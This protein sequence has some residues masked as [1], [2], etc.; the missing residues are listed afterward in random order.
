MSSDRGVTCS[1]CGAATPLPDD[2]LVPTFACAFC[3][4]TLTTADYAGE[5]AVSADALVGHIERLA[6]DP[7]AAMA[8]LDESVRSA[9]RFA[10]GS[11]EHREG[12]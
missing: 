11:R 4:A 10:G 6:A 7:K 9:P 5:A 12:A 3:H 2:L 1:A 8:N